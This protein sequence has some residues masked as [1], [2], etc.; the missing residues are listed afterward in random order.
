MSTFTLTR[1]THTSWADDDDDDFDFDT[2]KA[3]ADLSAPT[4]ISLPPLQLSRKQE[5]TPY[6]VHLPTEAAPWARIQDASP[7]R[8]Q[9]TNFDDLSGFE[10]TALRAMRDCVGAPPHTD[11][12]SW[13]D[14]TASPRERMNY[15][16]NWRRVK[17]DLGWDCRGVAMLVKTKLGEAETVEEEFT[18]TTLADLPSD[19]DA[20]VEGEALPELMPD[21][22]VKPIVVLDE[23]YYSDVSAPLSPTLSA[24][25]EGVSA[26]QVDLSLSDMPAPRR[27]RTDSLDAVATDGVVD[28]WSAG[29]RFFAADEEDV[30]MPDEVWGWSAAAVVAVGVLAGAG[31]WFCRRR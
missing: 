11:L 6:S 10:E 20:G 17:V 8:H 23:G 28:L 5:E 1:S 9:P 15:A 16:R 24:P 3:T 25:E 29:S 4:P 12:S 26:T 22:G 7:I 21:E 14:G 31:M 27:H 2:W 18:T 30:K 19:E 13:D